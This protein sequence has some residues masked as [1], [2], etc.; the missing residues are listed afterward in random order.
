MLAGHMAK[1]QSEPPKEAPAESEDDR[2]SAAD[3]TAETG[4]ESDRN[5]ESEDEESEDNAAG[6]SDDEDA[7]KA[8]AVASDEDDE[9]GPLVDDAEQ[10]AT[11]RR[12]SKRSQKKN[13]GA[14]GRKRARA[15]VTPLPSEQQI[16][17]PSRQTLGMLSVV[18]AATLVMWGVGRAKCNYREVGEGRKPRTVTLQ[19]RTRTPKDVAFEFQHAYATYDVDV[20]AKLATSAAKTL[21]A[22]RKSE[23]GT[24][25]GKKHE[26]LATKVSSASELLKRTA[27]NALARVWSEGN[28]SSGKHLVVLKREGRD[29]KASSYERDD[30]K[31][32]QLPGETTPMQKPSAAAPTA[33]GRAHPTS[34]PAASVPVP[35]HHAPGRI[36]Q[37]QGSAKR[38]PAVPPPAVS[39]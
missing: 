38:P 27:S 4:L 35:L 17:S 16:D 32:V 29:W 24:V 30:G 21:V 26:E 8:G 22:Q 33:S 23:C 36:P 11:E 19:E 39:R 34:A 25:C 5:E 10:Q 20:A 13:D 18:A 1:K 6:A 2:D 3:G 7:D 31:E 37:P 15:V 14:Q 28:G 12:R 9:D